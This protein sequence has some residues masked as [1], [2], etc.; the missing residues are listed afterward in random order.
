MSSHDE[1]T[2]TIKLPVNKLIEFS[3]PAN[4]RI[5]AVG[6]GYVSNRLQAPSLQFEGEG[7]GALKL[8]IET[9]DL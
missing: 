9:S 5:F 1:N 2:Y 6:R 7:G 3:C 4:S 8:K